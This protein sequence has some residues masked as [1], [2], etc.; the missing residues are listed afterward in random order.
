MFKN[1]KRYALCW[2]AI[3]L[4]SI[5]AV[6][7]SSAGQTTPAS[8]AG[9]SRPEAK[10]IITINL[11][12]RLPK[13]PVCAGKTH[14]ILVLT[15][16]DVDIPR[17]NGKVTHVSEDPQSGITVEVSV[18]NPDIGTVSPTKLVSGADFLDNPG[19]ATF[20]FDAHKAG[21]TIVAFKTK[22]GRKTSKPQETSIR[23]VNCE[24][25]V[26]MDATDI[27]S[28][29]GITLWIAG[30]L[31]TKITGEGSEMQGNGSFAFD[32]GFVGPPCTISYTGF[33]N[34]T[35]IT[36]HLTDDDQLMLDFKYQPGEITSQ[37]TCPEVSGGSTHVVDMTN[38]GIASAIF[39]TSGG[40]RMIRFTYA[41]SD[42]APGTMIIDVQPVSREVGS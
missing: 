27:D 37:V 23:V 25:K 34:P 20:G 5:L 38:A 1:Q 12:I 16:A 30:H 11:D 7:I 32:S 21:T 8:A 15:T 22:F 31:D 3:M 18:T 9:G 26:T 33:D 28:R 36:G 14:Y 10:S 17:K 39:P 29:S 2:R 4:R 13:E 24:Y 41:G 40:T 19:E 42:F 6:C 35:T